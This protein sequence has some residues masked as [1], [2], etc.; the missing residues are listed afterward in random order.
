M[1]A[2]KADNAHPYA[3][4]RTKEKMAGV[5]SRTAAP[6]NSGK[7]NRKGSSWSLR[8]LRKHT[9]EEV[10]IHLEA[11][12]SPSNASFVS[13]STTF[14]DV[15]PV[16]DQDGK[17]CLDPIKFNDCAYTVRSRRC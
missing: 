5:S 9:R 10:A 12:R 4:A 13:R 1:A 8:G 17:E 16:P 3:I 11:P 14:S 2:Q 15:P 6:I 7:M